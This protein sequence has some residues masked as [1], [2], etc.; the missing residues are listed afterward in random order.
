MKTI[1]I[2]DLRFPTF[3]QFKRGGW[4]KVL[5]YEFTFGIEVD[6]S[7]GIMTRGSM[8]FYLR[9]ENLPRD[10]TDK[11]LRIT[12]ANYEL[13]KKA[14]EDSRMRRLQELVG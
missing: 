1:T 13:A 11:G 4:F 8:K 5:D 7:A 6:G 2:N 10:L 3:E 14:I 12:E 9:G